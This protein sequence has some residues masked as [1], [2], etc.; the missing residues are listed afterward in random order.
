MQDVQ[1]VVQSRRTNHEFLLINRVHVCLF[2]VKIVPEQNHFEQ[3]GRRREE[4]GGGG[5]RRAAGWG[6]G[7]GGGGPGMKGG[8]CSCGYVM[9]Y[10]AGSPALSAVQRC[11]NRG[12]G[13]GLLRKRSP[14]LFTGWA[15]P[16]SISVS[17]WSCSAEGPQ[18]KWPLIPLT[19]V[20]DTRTTGSRGIDSGSLT[21]TRLHLVAGER[22]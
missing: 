1:E 6:G 2:R 15:E 14:S 10:A 3:G 22:P 19:R 16:P 9:R 4:E 18:T 5:R 13:G 21:L 8:Q 12:G 20:A 11:R 7:G 17:C